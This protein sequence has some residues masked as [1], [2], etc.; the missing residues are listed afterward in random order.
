[1]VASGQNT[2]IVPVQYHLAASRASAEVDF[3]TN[4]AEVTAQLKA[5]FD[6]YK[7][8]ATDLAPNLKA[9]NTLITKHLKN[10]NREQLA[11]LYLLDA[12]IYADGLKKTS[13]ARA[14]WQQIIR[15][16]PG[17]QAAQA[18]TIWIDRLDAEA[19]AEPNASIPE[20]LAVGQKFP[21]FNVT[22]LAG[23][24]LSP[25]DYRGRVTLIDFWATWCP[26]CRAELPNVIN[27]YN[28]EHAKGFDII[29]VSLDQDRASVLDFIR[30]QGMPW[31]QY[32][33]GQGWQNQLAV[34]YSVNSIP[35]TYLLDT[36]GIIIGKDLR[37]E[38]L[39]NAVAKA[40]ANL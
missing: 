25:E 18:S 21:N 11:R 36:H 19:A 10:G 27:I 35:M 1:L 23:S 15:D 30:E 5:K 33:D 34:K 12:H 22:S 7:T 9:I 14:I 40:L 8:T 24:S 4:L 31:E 37:G 16:F 13:R 20:G 38:E 2:A 26:P 28:T 32:F 3:S 17:T 29:G 39:E 6:D